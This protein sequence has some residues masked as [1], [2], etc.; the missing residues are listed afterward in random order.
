MTFYHDNSFQKIA[1]VDKI[2]FILFIQ[3]RLFYMVW[4]TCNS[5]M[6][7]S[8]LDQGTGCSNKIFIWSCHFL[9]SNLEI[10]WWLGHDYCLLNHHHSVLHGLSCLLG[11]KVNTKDPSLLN[12]LPAVSCSLDGVQN[13]LNHVVVSHRAGHLFTF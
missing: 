7:V 6:T 3:H 5:D 2:S 9:H 12:F 4:W 8:N 1:K 13:L 10:V 11:H